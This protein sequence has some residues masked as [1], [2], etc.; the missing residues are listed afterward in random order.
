MKADIQMKRNC[1][2]RE[3]PLGAEHAD[4]LSVAQGLATV[5]RFQGK[6]DESQRLYE[7]ALERRNKIDPNHLETLATVQGLEALYR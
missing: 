4:V 1:T 2:L 6:W 5:N 7:R 3:R